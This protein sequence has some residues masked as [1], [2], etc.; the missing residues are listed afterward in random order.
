VDQAEHARLVQAFQ[1]A[2][3]RGDLDALTAVLDPAVSLR[4]DGGGIVRAA[5]NPITGAGKVA[6]FLLGVLAK[7]PTVRLEPRTT[8][9]GPALALVRGDDVT[10]VINL[11]ADGDHITRVWIQW[12]PHKL[13]HW[14]GSGPD[15]SPP[16]TA[17][18]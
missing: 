1:D 15:A 7:Q 12:N 4:S 17:P 9:D 3:R 11:Q 10:A 2:S 14:S 16:D 5:L 6:R 18:A 13:T 8:A